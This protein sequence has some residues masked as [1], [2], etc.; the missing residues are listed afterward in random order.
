MT[1][2]HNG[3]VSVAPCGHTGEVII[4]TYVRCLAGCEGG[5]Q[6]SKRGVI[7]HV[8]NCACKPCQIRRI[9]THIILR[10]KDGKDWMKVEWD[11]VQDVIELEATKSVILRG[12]Q[13][14]DKDGH[15]VAR[16]TIDASLFIGKFKL[17]PTVMVDGL[18]S[19]MVVRQA[20]EQSTV[21]LVNALSI[22]IWAALGLPTQPGTMT[23]GSGGSGGTITT[24]PN[25]VVIGP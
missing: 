7:G 12:F 6:V 20:I 11:G 25:V 3:K 1:H 16:G 14:L 8:D 18:V 19:G 17:K 15:I 24:S 21:D 22:R 2:S 4:G 13:F 5:A 9:T 10:D 23:T